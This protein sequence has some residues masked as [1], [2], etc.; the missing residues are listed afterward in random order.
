[1]FDYICN[2]VAYVFSPR[3]QEGSRSLSLARVRPYQSAVAASMHVGTGVYACTR[4][5][6]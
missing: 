3:R 6:E 4:S 5:D 1:V 2:H